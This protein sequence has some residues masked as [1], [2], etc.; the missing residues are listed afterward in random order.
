MQLISGGSNN[1]YST[2]ATYFGWQ[3]P[4]GKTYGLR[5]QN[6]AMVNDSFEKPIAVD[7]MPSMF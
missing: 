4:L 5:Y 1:L 6:G 2:N 3:Q 7:N